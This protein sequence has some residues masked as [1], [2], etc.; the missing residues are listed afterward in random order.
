MAILKRRKQE[1]V[2]VAGS[3]GS[4][5]LLKVTVVGIEGEEVTLNFDVAAGVMV[6]SG[7]EW[8]S[9]LATRAA[10]AKQGTDRPLHKAA[11]SD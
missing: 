9:L 10:K 2:I 4:E 8:A 11:Y 6:H 3:G 7:E 5:Q 1:S